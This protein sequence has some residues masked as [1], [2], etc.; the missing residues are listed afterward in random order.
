MCEVEKKER[1]GKTLG[2]M[3]SEEFIL[4]ADR[5]LNRMRRHKADT[6]Q[7]EQALARMEAKRLVWVEHMEQEALQAQQ[8]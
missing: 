6:I 1:G 7:I 4:H 8:G 3:S 2:Q 5:V